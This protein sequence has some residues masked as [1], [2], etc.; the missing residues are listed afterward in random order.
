M[1]LTLANLHSEKLVLHEEDFPIPENLTPLFPTLIGS[2][3]KY[4]EFRN[5]ADGEVIKTT[6]PLR[7]S[8]EN[9]LIDVDWMCP[10]RRLGCWWS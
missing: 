6:K 5:K 1:P 3:M 7:V 10:I 2:G 4:F 9:D 8:A